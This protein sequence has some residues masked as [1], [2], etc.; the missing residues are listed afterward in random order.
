MLQKLARRKAALSHIDW[1]EERKQ[2]VKAV[3]T[4]DFISSESE[5]E[6]HMT[7][8][9]LWWESDELRL[10]KLDLDDVFIAKVAT[11]RQ[12]RMMRPLSRSADFSQR[13][14]PSLAQAWTCT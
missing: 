10:T 13:D 6:D 4:P 12:R 5:D 1:V 9:Q 2:K 7:A 11:K 3:M 14:I 8:K